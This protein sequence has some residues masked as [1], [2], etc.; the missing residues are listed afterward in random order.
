MR[1]RLRAASRRCGRTAG[2]AAR[3]CRYVWP[4][5]LSLRRLRS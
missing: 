5:R 4:W 1:E 3:A 2:S